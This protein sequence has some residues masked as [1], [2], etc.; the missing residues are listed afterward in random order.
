MADTGGVFRYETQILDLRN[1]WSAVLLASIKDY[2]YGR[3][4]GWEADPIKMNIIIQQHPETG[5][6]SDGT[7]YNSPKYAYD[8]ACEWLFS[9]DPRQR[10][11]I[12]V[13]SMLDYDP[14][15]IR[16]KLQLGET[17]RN[18]VALMKRETK[19]T[20]TH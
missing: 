19:C 7:R 2:L 14:E 8:M 16:A 1:L 11:F 6:C 20:E 10:G 9:N 13:C 4:R 18:Y 12:W 17:Y 5:Y 3:K 15:F